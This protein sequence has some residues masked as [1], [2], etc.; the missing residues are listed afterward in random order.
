[1]FLFFCIFAVQLLSSLKKARKYELNKLK[2]DYA[3]FFWF[4]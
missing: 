3:I 1:M 4:T 2:V